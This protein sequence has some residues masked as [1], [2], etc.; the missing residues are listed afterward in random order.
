MGA[1]PH[2]AGERIFGESR[3]SR[4]EEEINASLG[5]V[6]S[7]VTISEPPG[8]ADLSFQLAEQAVKSIEAGCL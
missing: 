7:T 5:P 6:H 2:D 8:P 3:L 1:D 4:L